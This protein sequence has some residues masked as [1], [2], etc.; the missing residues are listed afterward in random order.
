MTISAK[1]IADSI[2]TQKQIITTD[3]YNPKTF[4]LTTLQ[5]RYP[6]FIHAE[7][8]THRVFSRNASSSRAIPVERLIKDIIE[9][10]AMPM[11]WGKNQPGMQAKEEC[12]NYLYWG[13]AGGLLHGTRKEA[14]FTAR[15][16]AIVIARGFDAAGY[17]KQIVNR[18]LEP[19][20]HINVVVTATEWD[21]FFKLRIHPDAQPEICVLATEIK[22][23]MDEAIPNVLEPG[24]WHLPY[25]TYEDYKE[26][27]FL[28]QDLKRASAARCA[29]TSYLTHD[30]K[31]STV[32]KDLELFNKL[33]VAEPA[34]ASPV[35][36]QGTPDE[37]HS[38]W[39]R[40]K[41]PHLWGNFVGFCQYRKELGL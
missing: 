4:R 37:Y 10:T 16:N 30:G 8:M 36:H 5:L 1:I 31:K 14:W 17:H 13:D 34:H 27:N 24:Q 11:H 18:L 35:E 2:S 28:V 20:S 12:D 3:K 23:A 33:I 38:C 41:R 15:D 19:F 6:R 7:L 22:K 39:G 9:D 32:A 25:I 26:T 40:W 21:N 29:R